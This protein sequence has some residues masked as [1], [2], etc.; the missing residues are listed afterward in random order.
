MSLQHRV[1]IER[2][3]DKKPTVLDQYT[4]RVRQ[5]Q[6]GGGANARAYALKQDQLD[7]VKNLKTQLR[8]MEVN[9]GLNKQVR[10]KVRL[11]L[12]KSL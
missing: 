3:A 2:F 11:C 12:C 4:K 5:A 6:A 8:A 9:E 7:E 1:K 10:L